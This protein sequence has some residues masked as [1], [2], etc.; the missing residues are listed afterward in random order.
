[1]SSLLVLN[2]KDCQGLAWRPP[3]DLAFAAQKVLVPLHAGELSQAAATM[4]L[5]FTRLG[6]SWRLVGVCGLQSGHN[7]FIKKGK[8][9]GQYQPEWLGTWPFE[10]VSIGTKVLVVVDRDSDLVCKQGDSSGEPFFDQNGELALSAHQRVEVLRQSFGRQQATSKAL[11]AL[12]EH[13]V[14]TRWPQSLAEKIGL[15]VDNLYMADEKALAQ[16][17]DEAFLAL[18]RSQALPIAYAVNLSVPQT[19]LLGR[20]AKVNPGD[21]EAVDL[22]ALF[23]EDDDDLS[24]SFS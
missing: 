21:A 3:V 2:E 17:S 10:M 4:P 6:S 16:L 19:H 12:A 14:M 15:S 24:F 22:D 1:M 7:L 8:W 23:G 5:A 13:G 9:L 11:A 20:L 18:R